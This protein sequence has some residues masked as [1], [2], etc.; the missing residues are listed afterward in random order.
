MNGD[1][2]VREI[3]AKGIDVRKFKVMSDDME[4]TFMSVILSKYGMWC[5]S[6]LESSRT[7]RAGMSRGQETKLGVGLPTGVVGSRV[8]ILFLSRGRSQEEARDS[9]LKDLPSCPKE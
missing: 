2:A 1:V 5:N 8:S 3:D 7:C 4:K 6:G 9:P